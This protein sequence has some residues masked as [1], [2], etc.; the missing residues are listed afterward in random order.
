MNS[1]FYCARKRSWKFSG[2]HNFGTL[3]ATTK[4]PTHRWQC[5]N[6]FRR[7]ENSKSPVNTYT[8]RFNSSRG[9]SF[10]LAL[11]INLIGKWQK[12]KVLLP[13]NRETSYLQFVQSGE[14]MGQVF[15]GKDR[16]DVGEAF[17]C[18]IKADGGMSWP[19]N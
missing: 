15:E 17:G 14:V 19:K 16:G 18:N 10:I 11:M 5:M 12:L 7:S 3:R 9:V 4:S 1:T 8:K 13:K 2:H 6:N